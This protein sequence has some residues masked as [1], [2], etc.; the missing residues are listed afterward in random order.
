MKRNQGMNRI[1]IAL[2]VILIATWYPYAP[3]FNGEEPFSG[4]ERVFYDWC[5]QPFA[6]LSITVAIVVLLIAISNNYGGKSILLSIVLLVVGTAT[7]TEQI[8][9][10]ARYTFAPLTY[11]EWRYELWKLR[12]THFFLS[13]I[14]Y[15][16]L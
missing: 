15:S 14:D 12:N 16:S 13:K 6:L 1:C 2:V 8:Y 3:R 11:L 10:I 9:T 5:F 4:L 7:Y